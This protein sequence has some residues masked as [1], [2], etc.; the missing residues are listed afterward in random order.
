LLM[1]VTR[2]GDHACMVMRTPIADAHMYY[3]RVGVNHGP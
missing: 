1:S 3:M 2:W